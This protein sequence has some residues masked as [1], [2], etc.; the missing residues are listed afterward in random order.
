MRVLMVTR[1]HE[2]KGV[3]YMLE[4]ANRVSLDLEVN[5]VG[6]G[7]YRRTLEAHLRG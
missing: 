1:L 2:F 3:Q 6:D 5:I 7:P 4:A